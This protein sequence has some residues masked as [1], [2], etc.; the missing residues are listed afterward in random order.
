MSWFGFTRAI[1]EELGLDP[2]RVQPTTTAAF[3]RPA[4]RPA[5]SVLSH[6]SLESAGVAPIRDWRASIRCY[7]SA[8]E[9]RE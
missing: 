8:A 4:P 2:D 3:P 9:S 6:V 1:F 5:W 7:L